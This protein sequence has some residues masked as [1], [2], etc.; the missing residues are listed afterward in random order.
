MLHV[1]FLFVLVTNESATVAFPPRVHPNVV[2]C[3]NPQNVKWQYSLG[4]VPGYMILHSHS[5]I[6]NWFSCCTI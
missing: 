6:H 4:Q 1:I 5:L 2:T 3:S